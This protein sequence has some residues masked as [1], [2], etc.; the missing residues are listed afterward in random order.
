M[1]I[2]M[3]RHDMHAGVGPA[4]RRSPWTWSRRSSG[5]EINSHARKLSLAG[6]S[7]GFRQL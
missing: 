2:F 3:D 4:A 5:H 7:C 6:F 1:P